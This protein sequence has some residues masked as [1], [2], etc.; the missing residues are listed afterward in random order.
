MKHHCTVNLITAL[1]EST[2]INFPFFL[3]LHAYS[4]TLHGLKLKKNA[5]NDF[6]ILQ[7]HSVHFS[8]SI[9][10]LHSD[11]TIYVPDKRVSISLT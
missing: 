7:L 2:Y 8:F 9:L 5:P 10:Q 3:P 6:S 11:K 4:Y 1:W